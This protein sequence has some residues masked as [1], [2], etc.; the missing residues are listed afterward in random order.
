METRQDQVVIY[1]V[2]HVPY[3]YVLEHTTVCVLDV[4]GPRAHIPVAPAHGPC[5]A[6]LQPRIFPWEEVATH[7]LQVFLQ[8]GRCNPLIPLL[9]LW[10]G[11]V[12]VEI[13]EH[14][15]CAPTGTLDDGRNNF[16]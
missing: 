6:I 10:C 1:V 9:A 5:G 8:Q 12:G 16:L 11:Q 14:Q 15:Q 7:V 3:R 13:F 4:V 2:S